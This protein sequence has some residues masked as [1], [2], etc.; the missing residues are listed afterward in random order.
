MFSFSPPPNFLSNKTIL[1]TGASDGIGKCCALNFEKY[2][3]RLILLGRSKEKLETL[4][5]LIQTVGSAE[6]VIH[7]LDFTKASAADY[8]QIAKSV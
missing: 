4:Y 1:I 6:I 3:A 2:G 8:I 5:D 7:P